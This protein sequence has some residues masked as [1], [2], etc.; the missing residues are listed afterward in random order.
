MAARGNDVFGP[1]IFGNPSV[2]STIAGSRTPGMF[3]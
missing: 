1:G 3:S 2:T